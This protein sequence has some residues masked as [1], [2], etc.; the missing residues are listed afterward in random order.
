MN[1]DQLT[2]AI[3]HFKPE[4][5]VI[6]VTG[7]TDAL[8]PKEEADSAADLILRKPF[9]RPRLHEAVQEVLVAT[10]GNMRRN[11]ERMSTGCRGIIQG[12]D[13]ADRPLLTKG[14]LE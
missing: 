11:R 1:G 14:S 13:G 8:K 2:E 4:T 12:L 3:K 9:S 5:P 6:L 7:F 10:Q